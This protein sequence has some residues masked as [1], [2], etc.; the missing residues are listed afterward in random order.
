MNVY[1]SSLV[2]LL[3]SAAL[4][5]LIHHE[6]RKRLIGCGGVV[7]GSLLG[8]YPSLMTLMAGS[9]ELRVLPSP[10]PGLSAT[11]GVD[12][13]SAFF[14]VAIFGLSAATGVYSFGYLK[15]QP[16]LLQTLPFFPLLVAAMAAVVM[17][18]DGFLFLVCWEIMSLASFFLVTTE[19]EI[20][21]VRVAGWIYLVA[22]HLATSFLM[23]FFILLSQKSG[24]FD[25]LFL[26]AVIGFGTKAGIFPFHVWLPQAHPA[27]PS[28]ISA[29]MSGAMIKTGIYGI[30]RVIPL[31]GPPPL[32]WGGLL[33]VMGILSAV[34][35]ALYSLMQ[36]D[37]KRLLAYSS[38]E[39][40]GIIT[41]GVGLGL[42][43][44]TRH[45][46]IVT[47]LGFGGAL[48]HVWNH[49][50]L[51]GALFL[52]TGVV[53]HATHTRMIDRLGGLLKRLPVTGT[54][55]LIAS[56]ALC[57]LPP[58]NGFVSEW[59]IYRGL[60]AGTQW[61]IDRFF[62]IAGILGIALAG[63]LILASFTKVIGVSFLGEPRHEVP[64]KGIG[65]LHEGSL[66][67]FLPLVFLV[68]IGLLIGIF[69]K[70]IWSPIRT[71]VQDLD[72]SL[73]GMPPELISLSLI[74]R[75]F[76]GFLALSGALLL[77][78]RIFIRQKNNRRAVTWDCGYSAPSPRMQYSSSSF[79]E[80]LS[81]F[82]RSI[83]RPQTLLKKPSG[84]FPQTASFA[85]DVEDLALQRFF[86]PLFGAFARSL[87]L[88]RKMQRGTIQAYLAMIFIA[89]IALLVWE[90]WFGI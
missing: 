71:I 17:A 43:G 62:A 31:L 15:N 49:T 76:A 60:L 83:L 30:L 25:L 68:T 59:I 13:L 16:R 78:Y 58:L 46:L 35:G 47:S 36:Q 19:H 50:I 65:E 84:I 5:R 87:G 23:V 53:V 39:N 1:F 21:E 44:M 88:F 10:I 56:L 66:Y 37:L 14:L 40:I 38:V 18:R 26:F 61:P 45:D 80:P 41:M 52:G 24:S 28:A 77:F 55:F 54:M 8:L 12:A 48:F 67:L 90:V 27:A 20:K 9:F 34:L 73:I 11:F 72:P 57:G 75:I 42:M 29:L 81:I 7:L 64:N 4:S 82:F 85:E 70:F 89:L 2:L 3:V 51:K 6:S 33:M 63:G 32:W 69:P 86:R 79:A 74:G 22:T